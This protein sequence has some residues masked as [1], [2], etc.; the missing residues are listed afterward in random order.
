MNVEMIDASGE[1]GISVVAELCQRVLD[2]EG[3]PEEWKT[4]IA[5]PIFKG[6]GDVL[7]CGSYRP[8]KLLE[9]D[10]K[11]VERVLEKRIQ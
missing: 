9:H 2:G 3:I 5:I 4:S 7:N 10:M 6:K 8:V 1:T 11:I